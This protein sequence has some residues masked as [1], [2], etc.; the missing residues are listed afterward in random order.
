MVSSVKLD[1]E[2]MKEKI[3]LIARVSDEN[4]R[5]A[6]VAQ[7]NRLEDYTVRKDWRKYTYHEFDESAYRDTRQKFADLVAEIEEASESQPCIV[8]FDKI[9]RYTRDISQAE[10]QR[11]GRLVNKGRI[12]IHFPSDNLYITKDSP[13]SDLFRLGIGM[14]L[15]QYYSDSIRDNVKRRFEQMR[16]DKIWL[17]RAP[18]GYLNYKNP[19]TEKKTVIVDKARAPYVVKAFEMR[20]EGISYAVI[21]KRLVDD[22]F[23]R[24]KSGGKPINKAFIERIIN[25]KFYYGV[26]VINGVEYPHKYEPLISRALY[27]Q[28]QEVG[29]SL[30]HTKTKYDSKDYT[31]K[32]I[33][34]CGKCGRVVSSFKSRNTIYLRC[35]SG[36]KECGNLNTAQALVI[37]DVVATIGDISIPPD[38]VDKVIDELRKRHDNQQFYY[39]HKIQETRAEY[40]KINAKLRQLYHDRLDGRITQE[41]HD[42]FANELTSRQQ[43]L[44]DRLILLTNDNKSFQITASYLLDLAQRADQLFK[45]S[46]PA[47]QQKLLGFVLSNIKLTDKKLTYDVNDPFKSIIKQKKKSLS[48]HNSNIWCG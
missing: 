20:A 9:D 19:A 43:D 18:V 11:F 14:L 3:F 45:S 5:P 48:A 42:E 22:G 1:R 38:L 15:A 40:D 32:K 29:R 16:K 27:N 7:K 8:V 4:Q 2:E 12:E 10:V 36:G 34:T 26:M 25:N 37:D 13:A 24:V 39:T 30:K 17:H 28:C 33:V 6:L 21:A 23:T 44:N 47:L 35:A 41:F 46:E 31:F